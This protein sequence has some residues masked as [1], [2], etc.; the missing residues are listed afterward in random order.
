MTT[1]KETTSAAYAI[2]ESVAIIMRLIGED[3]LPHDFTNKVMTNPK[4]KLMPWLVKAL[5]PTQT[6]SELATIREE[7]ADLA[8]IYDCNLP[9]HFT[10]KEQS[11]YILG[12][13][14]RFN[15]QQ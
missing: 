7:L 12:F 14:K 13:S 15:R 11:D 9:T 5:N 2:G 3:N 1:N 8:Y 4:D 10:P 6:A